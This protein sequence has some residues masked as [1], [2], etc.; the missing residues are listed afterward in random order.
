MKQG[1]NLLMV[2]RWLPIA[3]GVVLLASLGCAA[4]VQQG[5]ETITETAGVAEPKPVGLSEDVQVVNFSMDCDVLAAAQK[6][7][8]LSFVKNEGRA[9]A[10]HFELLRTLLV[11]RI[12]LA[13]SVNYGRPGRV[14]EIRFAFSR[15]YLS[16]NDRVDLVGWRLTGICESHWKAER[17]T[18]SHIAGTQFAAGQR[19]YPRSL[20][21]DEVLVRV[22][23][24]KVIYQ[25]SYESQSSSYQRDYIELF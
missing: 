21:Q 18:D 2:W 25:G 5:A 4:L 20:I 12:H 3:G 23:P 22:A 7:L 17:M 6:A 13:K 24:L 10:P 11:V 14:R 1:L 19:R 16:P 15:D 9:V 8:N